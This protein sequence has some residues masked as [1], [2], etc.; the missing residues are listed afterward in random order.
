M[1]S[2]VEVMKMNAVSRDSLLKRS[3]LMTS[4]RTERRKTEW[5]E[6]M[7]DSNATAEQK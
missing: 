5:N 2:L 4:I 6:T 3:P 1:T 7:K